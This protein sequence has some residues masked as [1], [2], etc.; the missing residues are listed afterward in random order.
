[1]IMNEHTEPSSKLFV[2]IMFP[3]NSLVSQDFQLHLEH[4][5]SDYGW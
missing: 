4:W 2:L 5:V 3:S 1:M